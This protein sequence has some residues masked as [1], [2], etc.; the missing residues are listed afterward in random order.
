VQSTDSVSTPSKRDEIQWPALENLKPG[1][2]K[3]TVSTIM[4]EWEKSLTPPPEERQD[5]L[6]K[7]I[8][9]LSGEMPSK[10][11]PPRE[12]GSTQ[13]DAVRTLSR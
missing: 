7:S 5:L 6:P 2:L 13:E 3:R 8:M 10:S 11:L 12:N 4:K 9:R 1:N